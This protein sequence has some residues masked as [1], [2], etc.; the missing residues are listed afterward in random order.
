MNTEPT[1]SDEETLRAF[2]RYTH[3]LWEA[4]MSPSA[5]PELPRLRDYSLTRTP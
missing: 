2:R 3:D 5:N 1:T 4:L